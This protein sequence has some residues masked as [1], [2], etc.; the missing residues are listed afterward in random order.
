MSGAASTPL[1]IR[2][3]WFSVWECMELF[4]MFNM[5]EGKYIHTQHISYFYF[6]FDAFH[7]K[8]EMQK[9]SFKE[10]DASC[11]FTVLLS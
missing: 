11:K 9:S 7:L 5:T 6:H 3:E 2:R 8:N 10:K 4:N 1:R